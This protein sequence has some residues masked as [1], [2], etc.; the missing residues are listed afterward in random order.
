MEGIKRE[1]KFYPPEYNT[2]TKWCFYFQCKLCIVIYL[3][4]SFSFSFFWPTSSR[5]LLPLP[6]LLTQQEI[7][8]LCLSVCVRMNM[9]AYLTVR[10][11]VEIFK[12][13]SSALSRMQTSAEASSPAAAAIEGHS[14]LPDK[15]FFPPALSRSV[16][17]LLPVNHPFPPFPSR[18]RSVTSWA[19]WVSINF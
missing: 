16:S 6:L 5:H 11:C 13:L 9:R 19:L 4:G 2:N 15:T 14:S 7:W 12:R 17:P 3:W 8:K 10:F 18:G 1:I